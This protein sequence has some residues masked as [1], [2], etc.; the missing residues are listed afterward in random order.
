MAEKAITI[1]EIADLAGVSKATVS[2]V[3]ND[4]P[5]VNPETKERIEAI[6][7]ERGYFPSALAQAFSNQRSMMIGL[8]FPDDETHAFSNPYYSEL[9]R[10]I[11]GTAHERKYRI[12]LSYLE[13]DCFILARQKSVDGLLILTPG[14]DH[15]DRLTE[16]LQLGIPVVSTSRVPGMTGL[17]YVA[18]DEYSASC[19]IVEYLVSLGHKR[20]GYI[21]GPRTLFSSTSRLRGYTAVLKK[22]GIPY[23]SNLVGYGDTSIVSGEVAMNKLLDSTDVTAVFIG[24]D[25][26]AIG[27]KHAI[28]ARG[29]RVPE[30]ISLVT[31][32]ATEI[33]NYLDTPLTSMNQPTFQRGALAME[34][35]LDMVE[36]KEVKDYIM[37]PMD[38]AV[39]NTTNVAPKS[40]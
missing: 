22:Y 26:M 34:M 8:V 10:G 29:L 1:Q 14:T 27:A 32:D 19:Q 36:G 24:S 6:M 23:D 37:L 39:R 20:I 13:K 15:K 38:I 2:R 33:V 11:L 7:N 16:L 17:H 31:S 35:L 18:V 4:R 5:D 3:I 21:S 12:V 30:D 40:E 25:L 9:M 28:E